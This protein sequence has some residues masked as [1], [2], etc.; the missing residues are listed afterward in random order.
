[1]GHYNEPLLTI[2]HSLP[3]K[4]SQKCFYLL[5]YDPLTGEWQVE[6]YDKKQ[7]DS[8]LIKL[9]NTNQFQ[10]VK[11]VAETTAT[12]GN[13]NNN[14]SESTTSMEVEKSIVKEGDKKSTQ[15]IQLLIGNEH[16]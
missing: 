9:L 4:D 13:N 14:K 3:S 2:T 7:K 6:H 11:G 12:S 1:M 10:I 15:T 16:Q 8:Q 5:S